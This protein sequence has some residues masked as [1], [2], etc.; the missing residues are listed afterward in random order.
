MA[1]D[2]KITK[3]ARK[4]LA[5]RRGEHAS[6]GENDRRD[7]DG[8]RIPDEPMTRRPP[9]VGRR[10]L[11]DDEDEEEFPEGEEGV[12]PKPRAKSK[13]RT[14]GT[15]TRA[16]AKR[17]GRDEE[18]EEDEDVRVPDEPMGDDG[19][20]L[21]PASSKANGSRKRA[22]ED[23]GEAERE[24][25]DMG[26]D[27]ESLLTSLGDGDGLSHRSQSL[28]PPPEGEGDQAAAGTFYS[29]LFPA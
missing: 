24:A 13:A 19:D 22:R 18:E 16:G 3:N 7:E 20:A 9:A 26:G 4:K 25:M 11:R 29:F 27:D 6:D 15:Y 23:G 21:T 1:K 17:K 14:A 12:Q 2:D 28:P 8:F 5:D 10:P